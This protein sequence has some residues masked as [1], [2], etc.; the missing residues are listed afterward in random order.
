[1][2]RNYANISTS[3]WR[4]D[5]FRALTVGAQ[6][7]YLLLATQPDISAAGV[8]PLT[9]GRWASRAQGANVDTLTVALDE[10]VAHRFIVLDEDTQELLIRSFVK[11]D[12]GYNNS[13][14]RF[15]IKDAAEQIESG[16]LRA[17]LAVEFGRLDLPLDWIPAF[18]QVDS[19]SI[20][21]TENPD[22]PS[23]GYTDFRDS[24]RVVVTEGVVL[25]PQPT[26]HKPQPAALPADAG[27]NSEPGAA[28]QTTTAQKWTSVNNQPRTE[29]Q[30]VPRQPTTAMLLAE[31]RHQETERLPDAAK[32]VGRWLHSHGY[33]YATGADAMTIVQ[34]VAARYPGK[35]GLGYLQGIASGGGF[36]DFYQPLLDARAPQVQ[37]QILDLTAGKPD[38][39]HGFPGGDLPHPTTGVALCP[40]CRDG[41]PVKPKR[42]GETTHPDVRATLDAYRG[43]YREAYSALPL[44]PLLMSVTGEAETLRQRGITVAQLVSLAERA[45]A[46]GALL[47]ETARCLKGQPA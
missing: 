37:K 32:T 26:T 41:L 31:Q 29:G 5:D 2:A 39:G 7:T 21:H 27:S 12:G 42:L 22:S 36:M 45:G 24:R 35:A 23:K 44:L 47:L 25:R 1:M 40:G 20:A 17:A 28:A 43:S 14:R 30:R 8:L 11:W 10:L 18:S 33:P 9:L 38:C 19:L 13:K 4:D 3:I 34:A 16:E 46:N 15:A 6:H